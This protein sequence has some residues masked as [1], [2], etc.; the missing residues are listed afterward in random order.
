MMLSIRREKDFMNN[1]SHQYGQGHDSLPDIGCDRPDIVLEIPEREHEERLFLTE[2]LCVVDEEHFFVRGVIKIPIH[3]LERDLGIGV[4]VSHSEENYMTYIKNPDS[5]EIGPFFGW[6]SNEL[7]CYEEKTYC[8]KTM[9]H[10]LGNNMRPE[11]DLE[12]TDH[13][14]SLDQKNGISLQRAWDLVH[15]YIK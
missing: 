15:H 10:Y 3:D 1:Q 5:S 8:L 7:S 6:L 11:I 2:D 12:P 14:L 9:A 13:P 4:W